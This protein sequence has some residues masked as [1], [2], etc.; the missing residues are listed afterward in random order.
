[1]RRLPVIGAS[2]PAALTAE[3]LFERY[4]AGLYP[5]GV[6]LAELRRTDANPSKNPAIYRS[7]AETAEIFAKLAPQALAAESLEL[8][9]T[10]ASIHR[11]S[12]A[13]GKSA[14]DRM[15]SARP[16]PGE[17]PLF[18]HFVAHAVAY[19]G[20]C[21][22]RNHGGKWLVRSPLWESRV[23]LS[24]PAGL[25]EL[26]PFTWVLRAVAELD[27]GTTLA[28]RYRTLVEIPCLDTG[29]WPVF[30]PTDKRIPRLGKARYDT[31]FKHLERH[32]PELRD[33]G[34]HFPPPQRFAELS[35]QWLEFLPV[36]GGRALVMFGPVKSGAMAMWL[37]NEGFLKSLFVECDSVPEPR[38]VRVPPGDANGPERVRFT[39]SRAGREASHEVLWWGP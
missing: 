23:E 38:A 8:D 35:F 33:F 37:T 13:L 12:L 9:G 6:D 15:V 14:L 2:K 32:L 17:P 4:F 27:T 5:V 30:A 31:L 22:V 24:S 16:A 36:G 7:I 19:I 1:M 34:E 25:A 28:D 3:V 29:N 39:F 10:D 18:V 20:E 11:L 21:I 26:A